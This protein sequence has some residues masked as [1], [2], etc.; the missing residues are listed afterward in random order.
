MRIGWR[1]AIK[2]ILACAVSEV[3]RI[4]CRW[5]LGCLV[6]LPTL[7]GLAF[8]IHIQCGGSA[9]TSVGYMAPLGAEQNL[10][11]MRL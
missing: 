2:A 4:W 1:Q 7:R 9:I 11:P 5:N 10:R 3:L 8:L 6:D